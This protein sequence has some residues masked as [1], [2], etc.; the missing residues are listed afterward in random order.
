MSTPET[1]DVTPEPPPQPKTSVLAVVSFVLGLT[2]FLLITIPVNLVVGVVALIRTGD[3]AQGG[4]T[5]ALIGIVLSVLWAGAAAVGAVTVVNAAKTT[6]PAVAS[7]TA[8]PPEATPVPSDLPSGLPP[9]NFKVGD[10]M[11]PSRGQFADVGTVPCSEPNGGRVFAIIPVA[12]SW[13]GG[14]KL[15]SIAIDGCASRYASAKL[16]AGHEEAIIY[17]RPSE[18]SWASG[19][20]KI[21]CIIPSKFTAP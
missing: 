1:D 2:G 7:P 10:C 3:R 11:K 4:R 9:I 8:T 21:F 19:D 13:P 5:L 20:H 14:D 17:M 15:L 12:G 16:P 18:S 6:P